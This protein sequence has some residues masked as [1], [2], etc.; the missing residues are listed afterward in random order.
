MA[1]NGN[2]STTGQQSLISTDP[3]SLRP[4]LDLA[5]RAGTAAGEML[6]E[7]FRNADDLGVTHKGEGINNLV[8]EMDTAAEAMIR[9]ILSEREDIIFLGEES[10]GNTD[11]TQPTWVVD[12]IDGTVNYANR[13][14]IWCVSIAVVQENE[15]IV[16][17][18]VNP[19]LGER[20][21]ATKR[22]GA[23][24][25]GKRLSVSDH[26]DLQTSLLVTGFPYNINENP[27]NTID[28]FGEIL[29]HGI[30]V[31]R[32]GSA[33]LDLA[34][35]AAGRFEG[36]WEVSLHPW[37]VAAGLLILNEAGGSVSSYAPIG[38]LHSDAPTKEVVVDRLLATNGKVHET[39]LGVLRGE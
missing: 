39:L 21:T 22:G 6:L 27:H 10:G 30:A 5:V 18:I 33:A 11:L 36:F 2:A 13:L 3:D 8:T 1:D 34:Y 31:R 26:S 19:V 17:V 29:R 28:T 4:L 32:L 12:P 9:E 24:V 14:P 7:R 38:K 20:F 16:G 37:D 15:P 25:N 35:V 23:Y